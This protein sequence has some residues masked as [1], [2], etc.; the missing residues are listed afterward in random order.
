MGQVARTVGANSQPS[1][2]LNGINPGFNAEQQLVDVSGDH[3]YQPANF[4]AGDLRGPCPGL[5]AMANHGYVPRNGYGS[6]TDFVNGATAAYGMGADLAALL[7]VLGAVFSGDLTSWSIG[8][9][10]SAGLG[11]VLGSLPLGLLSAPMGISFSHNKYEG[12]ASPGRGDLYKY[13]NDY[14]LQLENFKALYDLQEGAENPNYDLGVLINHHSNRF[15]NSIA[16]NPYFFYGPFTGVGVSAAAHFFIYRMFGNKS[17]E[18]PEG[19]LNK[20]VL[21]SFFGVTGD[22]DNLQVNP[23]TERI[24]ENFYRRAVGDEYTIPF[25]GVDGVTE[26]L[27]YPKFATVGGNTGTVN[28]FTGV[29]IE[30]L[31]SGALNAQ[32]LLEGDNL[33]CFILQFAAQGEPDLLKGL[34]SNVGQ[35]QSVLDNI[36]GQA[37]SQLTCGPS[38][39]FDTSSFQQFPGYSQLKADGSY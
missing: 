38:I 30:H 1:K 28:S 14:K 32:S 33:M 17:A 29:D 7:S 4:A 18:N 39:T 37:T 15:D 20:E 23:G 36:L 13:G 21:K 22:G 27:Q 9:P 25:L 2:R 19:V 12:D 8:G 5:N 6:V 31:T 3:A 26:L 34:Y 16:T 11:N 35:A 10:P 24:P